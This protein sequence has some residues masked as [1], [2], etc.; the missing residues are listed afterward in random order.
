MAESW[1]GKY[2][3]LILVSRVGIYLIPMNLPTT[4]I[5]ALSVM[6]IALPMMA[7]ESFTVQPVSALAEASIPAFH[8]TP[9]LGV[10]GLDH[11][12]SSRTL[13]RWSV[14]SL[15]AANAADAASSW[16]SQEANPLVAGPATS[17]GVTSFAIKSGFVGASLLIQHVMLRHRPDLAK[18]MAWT[19]FIS[20]GALGG[21]AAHNMSLR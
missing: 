11:T 9:Q 16:R 12:S 8:S 6:L 21:V 2:Q 4:P 19:N 14:V 18:R 5:K 20:S 17:F 3:G 7:Q 1:Y 15:L 13:Y 10:H